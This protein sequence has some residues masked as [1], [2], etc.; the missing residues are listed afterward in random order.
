MKD[1]KVKLKLTGPM[2]QVPDSQKLFGALV[3]LFAEQYGSEK[4]TQLTK[5]VMSKE[6]HL[7]LSNV[8]PEGY[9]PTPQ[10]YLVDCIAENSSTDDNSKKIRAAIKIRYYIK[11]EDLESVLKKT[12][13]CETVYPYIKQQ[14]LQ[15]LRASIHSVRF[16]MPE[17]DTRLY[18]VPTVVL[19]EVSLDEEKREQ[20]RVVNDY[21]FYLQVDNSALC[22]DFVN[23][24]KEA[25]AEKQCI[26]LGKRASQGLN[27]FQFNDIVEPAIPNMGTNKFLNM[28]MLLPEAI[29]FDKS[30]IKLFTS[31]R[32][33]F[34]MS[35]GWNSE[36]SKQFISFIAQGSI[37]FV[38]QGVECAGKS[39]P[40]PFRKN[41]D[42]VFGN[43]YLYPIIQKAVQA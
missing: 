36:Y 4:A 10:D 39:I 7:A 37:I 11:S 15:Q 29:D 32:R 19:S 16:D 6:I 14:D 24:V 1:Y 12:E 42:I 2:T 34:E 13:K 20:S 28:G 41:R 21:Y 5:A 25:K 35:G 33:P 17:L 23:M 30:S 43:A 27:L 8:I 18:S 31:E 3:Y 40:S 26:I 9:L 38:S 22:S